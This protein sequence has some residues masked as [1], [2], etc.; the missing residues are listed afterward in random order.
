MA[1]TKKVCRS[2]QSILFYTLL[3]IINRNHTNTFLLINLQ[4]IITCSKYVIAAR[5]VNSGHVLLQKVNFG[6]KQ[7][8]QLK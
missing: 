1:S 3:H 6:R 8:F 2:G 5:A 4:K 7:T